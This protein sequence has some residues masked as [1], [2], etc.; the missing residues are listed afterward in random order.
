[1]HSL[2]ERESKNK[3]IYVPSHWRK[4]MAT[5]KKTGKSFSVQRVTKDNVYD[6]SD[7][8][9][10]QNW[11]T[12]VA[13]NVIRWTQVR[14]VKVVDSQSLEIRYEFNEGPVVLRTDSRRGRPVH[15]ATYSLKPA[16]TQPIPI[17]A[18]KRTDILSLCQLRAVPTKYHRFY[19]SLHFQETENA[20]EA[21]DEE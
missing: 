21:E 18:R 12:D 2:I 13:R 10:L 8:V 20:P 11:K 9:K 3:N 15:M 14:E 1:M 16:Y 17:K 5:A 4:V 7:L 6:F 19:E